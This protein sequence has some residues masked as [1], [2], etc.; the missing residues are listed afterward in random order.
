MMKILSIFHIYSA[1]NR[2]HLPRRTQHL[3][4][5]CERCKTLIFRL[6]CLTPTQTHLYTTP[7]LDWS[8]MAALHNSKRAE[9]GG[10]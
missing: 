3:I 6:I 2:Q 4:V 1:A 9:C 7:K 10:T 5:K 8:L